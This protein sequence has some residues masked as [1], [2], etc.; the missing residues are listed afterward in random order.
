[1][2]IKK[3]Q[4]VIDQFISS[5]PDPHPHQNLSSLYHVSYE[6]RFTD[7]KQIESNI[8]TLRDRS[9]TGILD[10]FRIRVVI[11]ACLLMMIFASWRLTLLTIGVAWGMKLF[12]LIP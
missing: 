8:S 12:L 10:K 1:M 9:S 4:G 3:V 7:F 6:E 11:L 5:R 2:Q